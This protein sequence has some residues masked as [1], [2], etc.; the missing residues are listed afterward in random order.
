MRVRAAVLAAVAALSLGGCGVP[1]T[2]VIE[3]GG[4][5]AI[6]VPRSSGALFLFFRSPDGRLMPMLRYLDMADFPPETPGV[7][8]SRAVA[9]LLA[10]PRASERK[11]GLVDGLPDLPFEGVARAEPHPE[12]GVEVT[13]PIPVGELDGL[14]VRQLVCTAAFAEDANGRTPVRLRGT[15]TALEPAV[16]DED[17]DFGGLP[18]RTTSPATA[19]LASSPPGR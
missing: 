6:K 9:E 13:L 3:A 10:G 4:P 17:V 1:E 19:P 18:S 7:P 5:A 16:C 12:G 2:D 8:T 11:T 14:A 15:D